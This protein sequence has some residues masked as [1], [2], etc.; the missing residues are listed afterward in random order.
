M[1]QLDSNDW[2]L[3]NRIIYKINS[4]EDLE[5]MQRTFLELLRLLI[6]FDIGTFYLADNQGPHLLGRPVGLNVDEDQ[7]QLYTDSFEDID[8]TKWVF[9]SAKSMAYRETDLFPDDVREESSLYKEMYAPNNLHFSAQLSL[10][11][12]EQFL[13]I[14]SLYRPKGKEDFSD[15]DLFVLEMLMDH[16][17]LRLSREPALGTGPVNAGKPVDFPALAETFGLTQRE[18]E[19][20]ALLFSEISDEEI[21]DNLCITMSTLKKHVQNIYQKSGARTRLQLYKLVNGRAR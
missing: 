2:I 13:G 11:H 4:I 12:D 17:A 14:V 5:K 8:Y 3:L 15:R 1:K 9:M 16:L 18:A 20:F 21:C 10:A 7:L 19:V 6:P